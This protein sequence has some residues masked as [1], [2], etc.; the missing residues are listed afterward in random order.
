MLNAN[1]MNNKSHKPLE[2]TNK[3]IEIDAVKKTCRASNYAQTEP[4]NNRTLMT[5]LKL[6]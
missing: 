2:I 1:G 5:H 3:N 4:A 6:K